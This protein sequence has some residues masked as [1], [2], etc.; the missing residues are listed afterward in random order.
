MK[1]LGPLWRGFHRCRSIKREK[2]DAAM[3]QLD[4][5]VTRPQ[6]PLQLRPQSTQQL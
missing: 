6:H 1:V 5:R 4:A 3:K 2:L